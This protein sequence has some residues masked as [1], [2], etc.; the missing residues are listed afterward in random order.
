MTS[1]EIE[2]A[3]KIMLGTTEAVAMYIVSTKIWPT[4]SAPQPHDY[5]KDYFTIESLANNNTI[6]IEKRNSP[7]DISL[8]YST[9]NGITWTSLTIS[10]NQNLTTINSGDKLLIKGTNEK[11]ATAWDSYY[12]F[13]GTGN[14]KV[15]GNAM[16]LLWGDNFTNNSEFASG[17]KT[18]L[19]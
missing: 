7:S 13:Y 15:Y 19:A 4:G 3:S 5:S 12:R 18:N 1:T 14:F 2:S 6:K 16:S 10:S 8:S 11:L 17:T 9:D